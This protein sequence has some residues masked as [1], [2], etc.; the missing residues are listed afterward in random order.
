MLLPLLMGTLL[1]GAALPAAPGHDLLTGL[2]ALRAAPI[3]CPDGLRP[4]TRPLRWNDTLSRAARVQAVYLAA[5]GQVTH[6]GKD[7]SQPRDRAGRLGVH[8]TQ[9]TEMVYLGQR[10]DPQRALGWWQ[11]DT[12]H[13]HIMADPRFSE[14]GASVVAGPG[15][16]AVVV[17]FSGSR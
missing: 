8:A 7:G 16:V 1:L 11:R 12:L 5:S 15:G 9:L 14:A 6:S 2:N 3:R 13:C 10:P 4:A 17:V